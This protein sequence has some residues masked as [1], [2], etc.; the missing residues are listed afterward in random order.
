MI[1]QAN[2]ELKEYAVQ[3]GVK[4]WEIAHAF[5][6]SDANFSRSMRK[7]LPDELKKEW[8]KTVDEIS[9][10]NREYYTD[11]I[12]KYNE[13]IKFHNMLNREILTEKFMCSFDYGTKK[14]L[15]VYAAK[16]GITMNDLINDA[17]KTF[18]KEDE[19]D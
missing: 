4:M 7:E 12:K 11:S 3:K 5:G 16:H 14:K 9:N 13:N 6:Y 17:V 8:Y 10:G 18:L 2:K 1:N 19:D 15:K